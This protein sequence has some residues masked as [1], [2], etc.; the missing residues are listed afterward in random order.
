MAPS[1]EGGLCKRGQGPSGQCHVLQRV[2]GPLKASTM[3]NV[4]REQ[5]GHSCRV[6]PIGEIVMPV[7]P[8]PIT[9]TDFEASLRAGKPW[10]SASMR[11][12]IPPRGSRNGARK[13][14]L[15]RL[16]SISRSGFSTGIAASATWNSNRRCSSR[17]ANSG[18][19]CTWSSPLTPELRISLLHLSEGAAGAAPD[20]GFG[21]WTLPV[22]GGQYRATRRGGGE[23]RFRR[24]R[25]QVSNSVPGACQDWRQRFVYTLRLPF[26]TG[27][28][29]RTS[30]LD[31]SGVRYAGRSGRLPRSAR[32]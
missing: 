24:A 18:A 2:A 22:A 26:A 8:L 11:S 17:N 31:R 12:P 20:H 4:A 14:I 1:G 9:Q 32:T 19:P 10:T 7:I 6:L 3:A 30:R 15:W 25:R 27:L 29:A 21:S 5:A 28:E 23:G 13:T 16:P